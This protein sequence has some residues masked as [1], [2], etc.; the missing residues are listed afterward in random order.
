MWSS[1]SEKGKKEL[2]IIVV[3]CQ[4]KKRDGWVGEQTIRPSPRGKERQERVTQD[5]NHIHT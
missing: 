5:M 3:S 1:K 2:E 4:E